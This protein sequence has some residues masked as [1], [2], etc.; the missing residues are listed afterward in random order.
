MLIFDYYTKKWYH[1]PSLSSYVKKEYKHTLLVDSHWYSTTKILN[2]NEP[3]FYMHALLGLRHSFWYNPITQV[4]NRVPNIETILTKYDDVEAVAQY[5]N[6]IYFSYQ[7]SYFHYLRYDCT[8]SICH[9]MKPMNNTRAY[10]ASV[11]FRDQLFVFGGT[12]DYDSLLSTCECYNFISDSWTSLPDM[13]EAKSTMNAIILDSN[14]IAIL[15]GN[16]CS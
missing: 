7:T 3:I 6:T 11:A 13:P 5:N 8:T 12:R 14:T 10:A 15:G 4:V 16:K 9:P 1:N 2:N